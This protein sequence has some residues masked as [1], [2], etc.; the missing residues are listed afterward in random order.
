M[1]YQKLS[2]P[3]SLNPKSPEKSASIASQSVPSP[4]TPIAHFHNFTQI[5]VHSPV[6]QAKLTIGAPND[7]YEQEADRVAAQVVQQLHRPASIQSSDVLDE[8]IQAKSILQRPDAIGSGEASTQ[9]SSE[10]NNRRGGG[11]PLEVGL[12][13]SM[14]QAMG[15]DFSR[16]RVHTDG[17]SDRL[18]R[19]IQ[20]K[21]FTT[22][23]DI[24]FRRGAYQ[25]VSR[26]GQQLI[27]HELTHVVQQKGVADQR[28]CQDNFSDAT[29]QRVVHTGID[30][31]VGYL[32]GVDRSLLYG[33]HPTRQVTQGRLAVQDGVAGPNARRTIDDYNA[34]IG[35]NA[36]MTVNQ[37]GVGLFTVREALAQANPLATWGVYFPQAAAAVAADVNLQAWIQKLAGNRQRIGLEDFGNRTKVGKLGFRQRAGRKKIESKNRFTKNLGD[38]AAGR[39]NNTT[40][41]QINQF[42]Q[43]GHNFNT[44]FT[45]FTGMTSAQRDAV[46]QFVY[47]A[48]F[49]RT[50]KLGV[51]FAIADLHSN[52]NFNTA[53]AVD[54]T[55]T[56]LQ[57]ARNRP[58]GL[59]MTNQMIDQSENRAITVSELRYIRKGI[60]NGT[61]NPANI[62][63][64]DET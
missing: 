38:P 47:K 62:N 5:P 59:I 31:L 18:N 58:K 35:I 53:A 28:S 45:A 3:A 41:A 10:I 33:M 2:K 49:R 51:D 39:A 26:G 36:L 42:L 12:Q 7:R 24:F 64:Y 60:A 30:P 56:D 11:Q 55:S 43:P 40:P 52:V 46:N 20:A 23:R 50:S 13:Q 22:G 57:V 17:G 1:V 4:R 16:V 34:D 63:F 21:A 8:T 54:H 32:S 29:I 19:S 14:G 27:A 61:I 25:P 6:I 9:L 48:F 37:A 44:A 15:A